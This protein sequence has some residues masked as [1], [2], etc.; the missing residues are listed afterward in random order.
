MMIDVTI[1]TKKLVT[2][3]NIGMNLFFLIIAKVFIKPS[4]NDLSSKIIKIN[5]KR[6]RKNIILANIKTIIYKLNKYGFC[7]M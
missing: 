2:I 6:K 1:N 4:L 3:L 7:L 5:E